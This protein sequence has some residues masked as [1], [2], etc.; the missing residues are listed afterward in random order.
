M[1][2]FVPLNNVIFSSLSILIALVVSVYTT[3]LIGPSVYGTFLDIKQ[4]RFD[5]T[6]SRND[7]VNKVIKKKVAKAKKASK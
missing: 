5:A 6:L 1:L 2:L 3:L 4:A 7:T